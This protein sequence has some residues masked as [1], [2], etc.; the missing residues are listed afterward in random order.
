MLRYPDRTALSQK[1]GIDP[2]ARR[3]VSGVARDK[4]I[5][6][7]WAA[8]DRHAMLQQLAALDLALITP[9]NYSVLT[10]VPRPT[11]L[12]ALKRTLMATVAMMQSGLPTTLH[13]SASPEAE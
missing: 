12:P 2:N 8:K 7:Y 10:D 13:P 4:K 3:V 6:R 5:E 9:P 1:F 11:K